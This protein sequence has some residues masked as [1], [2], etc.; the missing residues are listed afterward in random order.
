MGVMVATAGADMIRRGFGGGLIGMGL[1]LCVMKR[2]FR[3]M[4]PPVQALARTGTSFS[5]P[6]GQGGEQKGR[7]ARDLHKTDHKPILAAI[8]PAGNFDLS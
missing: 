3:M 6:G 4:R 2:A 1:I 7:E 5:R 8:R